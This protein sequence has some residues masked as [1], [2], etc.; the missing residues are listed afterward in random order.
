[1]DLIDKAVA[2]I[3]AL[4]PKEQLLY[5]KAAKRFNVGCTTLA[6]RHQGCQ[7]PQYTQMPMDDSSTHNKNQSL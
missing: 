4:S 2:A 5:R 7:A 6:Q 3:K 1:M